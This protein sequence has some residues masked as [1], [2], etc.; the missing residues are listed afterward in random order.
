MNL[1]ILIA[2]YTYLDLSKPRYRIYFNKLNGYACLFTQFEVL[3]LRE[4]GGC[5]CQLAPSHPSYLPIFVDDKNLVRVSG[6]RLHAS[7]C[8][9]D[10]GAHDGVGEQ[11]GCQ[12]A[13]L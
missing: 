10:C 3:L 6:D 7:G 12:G 11:F 9:F 8:R 5:A 2:T 4:D 1:T 13:C